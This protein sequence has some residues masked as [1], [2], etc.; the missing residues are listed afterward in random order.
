MR[1]SVLLL[2]ALTLLGTVPLNAQS[3]I[4]DDQT[5]I[6]V[7]AV[8]H[9]E[10]VTVD[11]EFTVAVPPKLA[12]EVLTD[13]AH[14]SNFISNVKF[15]SVTEQHGNKLRVAQKGAAKHGPISFSFDSIREIEL[16]PTEKIS[17]HVLSGSMKK[18]DGTTLLRADG[19][20][21]R[22]VYHAESIPNTYVPP[23]IGTTFIENESRHQF[24]E[25]RIEMLKRQS[26]AP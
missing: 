7:H 26:A 12:W 3:A 22:V 6:T 14:M 2:A 24:E 10:T 18:L 17:S 23:V 19:S 4:G 15:S 1:H 11:A 21:T 8:K 16:V 9:G 20:G 13:F 25:M 5:P